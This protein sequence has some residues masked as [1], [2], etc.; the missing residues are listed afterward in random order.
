MSSMPDQSLSADEVAAFSHATSVCPSFNLRK[1]SRAISRYFDEALQPSGLRSGQ[2]I[3]LMTIARLGSPTYGQL[4]RDMV[5]DT[6]TIA[7]NLQPLAREGLI[8]LTPG[9][10]RRR[11]TVT[12]TDKGVDQIRTAIPLWRE[13]QK[14]F[15]DEVGADQWAN[16]LSGLS[17]TLRGARVL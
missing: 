9:P 13:A 6:S 4:A 8:S 10:D 17:V 15:V 5:M 14:R 11:K 12:V 2:L 16:M 3:M 7:R 1:A